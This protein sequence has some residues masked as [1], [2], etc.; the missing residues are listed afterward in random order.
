MERLSASIMYSH[1]ANGC[2]EPLSWDSFRK[3]LHAAVIEYG[4]VDH[5]VKDVLQHGATEYPAGL[6]S[7]CGGCWFAGQSGTVSIATLLWDMN[8]HGAT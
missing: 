6:F 2:T 4:F 5:H 8:A 3:K 1:Q 7:E